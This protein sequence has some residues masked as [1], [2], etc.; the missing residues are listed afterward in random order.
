MKL[1][2]H[3]TRNKIIVSAMWPGSFQMCET[4][5]H[6]CKLC[7]NY[8]RSPGA[9]H[10]RHFAKRR[11]C[12]GAQPPPRETRELVAVIEASEVELQDRGV[13]LAQGFFE[14]RPRDFGHRLGTWLQQW[15][16]GEAPT[17]ADALI[18]DDAAV[19]K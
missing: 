18:C 13:D 16:R 1:G 9:P 17:V 2:A 10:N 6:V 3:I 7:G 19:L 4:R 8:K 11:S 15:L 14:E 12:D 5:K